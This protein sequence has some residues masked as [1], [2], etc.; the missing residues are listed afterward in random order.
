VGI[1]DNTVEPYRSMRGTHLFHAAPSNCSQRARLVLEEKG[2]PWTSHLINLSANEHLTPE[3]QCLHPGGVVPALVHDGT[4]VIESNDIIRY[5]DE[6]YPGPSLL[7]ESKIEHEKLEQ[8]LSFSADLQESLKLLSY[9][10]LFAHRVKKSPAEMAEYSRL[11][12]NRP[13]VRWQQRFNDDDF[14][15]Y[16]LEAARSKFVVMLESLEDALRNQTWLCGDRY[17]LADISWTVNVH[18]GQLLDLRKP[19]LLGLEQYEQL[20]AWLT[21]VRQRPSYDRALTAY[22]PDWS[23]VDKF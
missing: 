5:I 12:Q 22:E 10:Y 7:P 9:T 14:S 21:R 6:R 3:Y 1:L 19:G 16:E 8:L 18:R 15:K 23:E 11:Q 4:V 2:V 20:K 17:G 13:L